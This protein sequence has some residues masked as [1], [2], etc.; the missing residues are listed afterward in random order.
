MQDVILGSTGAKVS[1]CWLGTVALGGWG[2]ADHRESVNVIR[3]AIDSGITAIDTAD[4][5]GE[6]AAE[7]MVG[8]G[9]AGRRDS[10]FLSTKFGFSPRTSQRVHT[11]GQDI[12]RHLE[13]SLRRLGTDHIDLY[14]VHRV[15]PSTDPEDLLVALSDLVASGKVGTIGTSMANAM[16]LRRLV[17][18][19]DARRLQAISVEQPPYSVFVREIEREVIPT[20]QELGIV[21][22]GFAPLNGGW[23]TGKYH[24]GAPA[25]SGS[26]AAT[27]PMRRERYAFDRPETIRKLELVDALENVARHSGRTLTQL[28]LGF[29]LSNPGV[30]ATIIGPRTREQL[31]DLVSPPPAA[32]EEEVLTEVDRLVTPGTTIDP[33]DLHGYQAT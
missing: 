20:C 11:A 6:G 3:A 21:L 19:A 9:I 10:V 7:E 13:G 18:G 29:A 1:R 31:D 30:D 8:A 22:V 27:W 28:A 4:S 16:I 25:P 32:L 17:R 2:E 33:H 14:F 12:H 23:L 26:R 24:R 15:A 5:Y